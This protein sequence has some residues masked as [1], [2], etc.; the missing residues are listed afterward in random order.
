MVELLLENVSKKYYIDNKEILVLDNINL[1]INKRESF[2]LVGPSGCGKTTL[3]RIIAGLEKPTTGKVYFHG[4]L[5]E[6]PNEKIMMIFQNFTLLPWKTVRENVELAL[7]HLP[8][9]KRAE[10]AHHYLSVVGMEGFA[11]NYPRDLSSGGKQRVEIA[12]A[13][14]REPDILILDEPFASLDPL[15]AQNIR[16]EILRYYYSKALKP[17]VLLL[18]THNIQEA[19]YMADKVIVLSQQPAHIK[20]ILDIDLD[21]PRDRKSKKFQDYVD[22][23][24]SLI[25]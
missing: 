5:L 15:T 24:T 19:I 10:K 25:T 8:P 23:I 1:K 9:D 17:D 3:S 20:A 2:A 21:W 6:E 16:N 4:K 13:L 14:A 11:D 18:I 7:L 12:R 22:E